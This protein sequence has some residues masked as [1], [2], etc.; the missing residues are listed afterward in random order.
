MTEG[1]LV[2]FEGWVGDVVEV[3]G[4]EDLLMSYSSIKGGG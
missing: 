4:P 3:F 1:S 2:P